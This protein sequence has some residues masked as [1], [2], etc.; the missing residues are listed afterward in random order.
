MSGF[1]NAGSVIGVSITVT[2]LSKLNSLGALF[3]C[4]MS[5]SH[6]AENTIGAPVLT[7]V[8]FVQFEKVCVAHVTA[9]FPVTGMKQVLLSIAHVSPL[10][11]SIYQSP[12]STSTPFVEV[13]ATVACLGSQNPSG[14]VTGVASTVVWLT[15]FSSN[16]V[17]STVYSLGFHVGF[18]SIFCITM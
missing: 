14:I 11:R 17:N 13:K 9:C 15:P 6:R 4:L 5:H 2:G 10:G 12:I 16:R 7:V 8:I 3:S 1:H 18:R